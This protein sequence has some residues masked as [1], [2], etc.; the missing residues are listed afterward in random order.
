MS[1]PRQCQSYWEL[2][3]RN[4]VAIFARVRNQITFVTITTSNSC[5]FHTNMADS[6]NT[7]MVHSL[8][9]FLPGASLIAFKLALEGKGEGGIDWGVRKPYFKKKNSTGHRWDLNLGSCR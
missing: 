8:L 9:D 2:P 3:N 5:L 6:V 7:L 1:V 4:H